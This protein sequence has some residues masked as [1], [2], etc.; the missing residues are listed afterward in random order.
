MKSCRKC[1]HQ[2]AS[3]T[4]KCPKCGF[5]PQSR[6]GF[7]VDG[8]TSSHDESGFRAEYFSELAKLE[9]ANFWFQSRNEL[10]LWAIRKYKPDPRNFLEMGCGTGFVISEVAQ[11]FPSAKLTGSEI[12]L[13]GLKFARCRAPTVD[14]IQMDA[15]NIPFINEFDA[16]GAFDVLE[17]IKEDEEVL[18]QLHKAIQ[19]GG[20][21]ILTVPQH[22]WLWSASDDYAR[23]V[24]RYTNEDLSRKV[25]KH[26]TIL[27]NTSFVS[28]LLPAMVLS[29]GK[30]AGK[31][32]R[33][34]DPKEELSLP[35]FLNDLFLVIMFIE[36]ILI[37][38]GINFPFGGSRML[39]ARKE[40]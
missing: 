3:S 19:P 9:S 22:P 40:H 30:N 15:R 20:I 21:L 28:L 17:H 10:I 2:F 35:R 13:D 4:W 31:E 11:E 14:L 23:H 27:R 1:D 8:E 36:G 37:K 39:V 24:R 29:R 12:F 7:V 33:E 38:L 26:F 34:Y 18:I 6:E 25:G 5:T 16:I 32:N